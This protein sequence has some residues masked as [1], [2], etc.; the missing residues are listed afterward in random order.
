MIDQQSMAMMFAD[1]TKQTQE[2][3]LVDL[4]QQFTAAIAGILTCPNITPA[5]ANILAAMR[6]CPLETTVVCIIGQDPYPADGVACGHAFGTVPGE[7]VPASLRMINKCLI[8]CGLLESEPDSGDL[9]A[10]A[11]QGVLLL[12]ASLTTVVGKSNAHIEYW[13]PFTD[14]L[15]AV[16]ASRFKPIFILLGEF[17]KKKRRF[18]PDCTV[19]EFGHPSPINTANKQKDNPKNFINCKAFLECNKELVVQKKPA[20]NW[21]IIG[22]PLKPYLIETLRAKTLPIC[23]QLT[24][25]KALYDTSSMFVFTDGGA[26]ANGKPSCVASWAYHITDGVKCAES[27]GIV[28]PIDIKEKLYK[29]SNNR[30][31]LMAILEAV[32]FIAA[33]GGGFKH[34]SIEIVTDSNYAIIRCDRCA[35]NWAGDDSILNYDLIKPIFDA[36]TELRKCV[37]VKF[38]HIRSHKVKPAAKFAAFLWQ[39][40]DFADKLCQVPL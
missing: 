5:P 28:P 8:K 22:I 12:N 14:A 26:R 4:K 3:I 1:L 11:R 25:A 16:I 37:Q 36:L 10:W 39:G 13:E 20:I 31:E 9:S 15:I 30:G 27:Y 32:K 7:P 23:A 35:D 21:G 2:I 24:D 29:S 38:R 18:A 19:F 17:A 33:N 6:D 34:D 40:N